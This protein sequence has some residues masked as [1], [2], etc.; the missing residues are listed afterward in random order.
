MAKSKCKT[1]DKI[2]GQKGELLVRGH[3]LMI[4]YLDEDEKT[5]EAITPARWY[6]TG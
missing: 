4:G 2:L 3:N 5:K 6:R 1:F